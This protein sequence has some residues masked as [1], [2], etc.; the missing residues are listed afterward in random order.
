M[1]IIPL[2]WDWITCLQHGNEQKWVSSFTS[3]SP[4]EHK[5]SILVLKVGKLAP[6]PDFRNEVKTSLLVFN[7]NMFLPW[8]CLQQ[9]IALQHAAEPIIKGLFPWTYPY[10]TVIFTWIFINQATLNPKPQIKCYLG[11]KKGKH[12][13]YDYSTTKA[14][15][16]RMCHFVSC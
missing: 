6:F 9:G 13:I 16:D 11:S 8:P 2:L 12:Y 3:V 4:H 7:H 14:L 10:K 5:S 1:Y 15:T